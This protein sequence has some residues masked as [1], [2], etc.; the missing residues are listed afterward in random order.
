MKTR[1]LINYISCLACALLLAGCAAAATTAN[2]VMVEAAPAFAPTTASLEPVPAQ[3][4]ARLFPVETLAVADGESHV[5]LL[6]PP[7][8][9][10][11]DMP[12]APEDT[13]EGTPQATA[14]V[15]PTEEPEPAP[16]ST[17]KPKQTEKPSPTPDYTVEELDEYVD[18]YVNSKTINLRKGPGT[19]YEVL[20]EYERYDELLVTGACEEWYRVKLDGLRGYMLQEYVTIGSLPTPTPKATPTPQPTA[21]PKPTPTP[22]PQPTATPKPD[23]TQ[24]P[25]NPSISEADELYLVAQVVYKEG[26]SES[27]VAVANVIYNRI[28]NSGFPDTAYEVIYQKNQF[29][30]SNLKSPSSGAMAA[31]QQIFVERDLILP[32][33]VLYFQ[34]ASKGTSRSGYQYYGSYG[35]NAFFYK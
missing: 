20:G 18:G 30:T 32:A 3:A 9:T 7:P 35:G 12:S 19:D 34:S 28:L 25:A 22:A 4:D 5:V 31:V 2:V 13:G 33:E 14:S 23:P 16:A 27:Y 21:T 24:A 1:R 8:D 6:T 17:P 29:S 15:E 26:D 11:A 10:A